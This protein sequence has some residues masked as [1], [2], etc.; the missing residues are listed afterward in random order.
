ME[1]VPLRLRLPIGEILLN[2]PRN[3][4]LQEQDE[5]VV[6]AEDDSTINFS[7]ETLFE[8]KVHPYSNQKKVLPEEHHLIVG[9]NNK[10][11]IVLSEYA[12]YMAPGSSVDLLI[13]ANADPEIREEFEEIASSFP[14]VQMKF[15]ESIFSL[16]K[17]WITWGSQATPRSR[18]VSYT[19]LTL[20]TKR[21]V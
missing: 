20:P 5:I 15:N 7:S 10:A 11:P 1:S 18:S 13:E 17:S 6:L 8:P 9:W 3:R 2:P 12:D 21:I 16:K 14:D 4:I 19:H